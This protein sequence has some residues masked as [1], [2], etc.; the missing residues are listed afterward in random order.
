MN[1]VKESQ[2]DTIKEAVQ[3]FAASNK[4]TSEA[5][6]TLAN[7]TQELNSHVQALSSANA[8]MQEK[9]AS[10]NQQMAFMA[11]N[12]GN[13][14][15]QGWFT[16]KK[17]KKRKAKGYNNYNQFNNGGQFPNQGPPIQQNNMP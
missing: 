16:N 11:I 6:A 13:Q 2:Q 7:T 8:Q 15:N 4:A 9:M 10:M 14:S 17:N 5:F 3:N 1:N 12:Q